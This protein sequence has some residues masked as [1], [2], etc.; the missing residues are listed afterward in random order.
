MGEEEGGIVFGMGI[1][2]DLFQIDG[3]EPV[4][5]ERLKMCCNGTT[6]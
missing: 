4:E 3:K 1:T 2:V 5:M 6:M